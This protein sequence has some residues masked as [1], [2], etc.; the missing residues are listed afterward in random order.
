MTATITKL[1]ADAKTATQV[2][3][4]QLANIVTPPVAGLANVDAKP[5]RAE[6]WAKYATLTI[7]EKSAFYRANE[8]IM[9]ATK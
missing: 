4:E 6:L 7:T 8:Q 1:E 5:T 3:G 9:S 2:A